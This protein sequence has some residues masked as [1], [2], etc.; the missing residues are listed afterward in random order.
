MSLPFGFSSEKL[1]IGIQLTSSH[2]DEQRML[3]VALALE[4][5]SSAKGALPNV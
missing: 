3:N 5:V 4:N 1:P 2:F